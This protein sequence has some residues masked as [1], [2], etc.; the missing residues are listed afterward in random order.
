MSLR[1]SHCAA[2]SANADGIVACRRGLVCY[3]GVMEA[4][5]HAPLTPEQLAAI[6]AGGGFARCED[7]A[8]HVRYQLIQLQ[9][10]TIDDD[11]VRAKLAEAQADCD[12]GDVADWDVDAVKKELN[13]RLARKRTGP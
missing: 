13:D 9:P 1:P 8:T 2:T 10:I 6:H 5:H 4:A 11:Y 3:N 7:P 12:R